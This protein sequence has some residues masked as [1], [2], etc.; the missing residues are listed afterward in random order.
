[1]GK[2]P[3]SNQKMRGMD[4]EGDGQN[5]SILPT[6]AHIWGAVDF[7]GPYFSSD[8]SLHFRFPRAIWMSVASGRES[9]P[10]PTL[11]PCGRGWQAHQANGVVC[12]AAKTLNEFSACEGGRLAGPGTSSL[13]VLRAHYTNTASFLLGPSHTQLWR[14][15]QK[16]LLISAL[17]GISLFVSW[18]PRGSLRASG[19][20]S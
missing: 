1:M 5:T 7:L 12:R 4:W 13:F 14:E 18:R 11:T 17:E 2:P 15:A 3:L 10:D 20:R 6:L 16:P 8:R 19:V 9:C